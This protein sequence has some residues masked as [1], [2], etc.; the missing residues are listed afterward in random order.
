MIEFDPQIIAFLGIVGSAGAAWGVV[1]GT[2]GHLRSWVKDLS[3]DHKK[4]KEDDNRVHLEVVQRLARIE[5]KIDSMRKDN[6]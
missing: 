3:E 4:H 5:T 2:Q 6:K 1:R